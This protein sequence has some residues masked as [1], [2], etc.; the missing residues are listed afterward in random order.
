MWQAE[1]VNVQKYEAVTRL[2]EGVSG[3]DRYGNPV[4]EEL[5]EELP[6]ARFVPGGMIETVSPGRATVMLNPTLYWRHLWPD[7]APSDR[8]VVRGDVYEVE[9]EPGDWQGKRVGGLVVQLRAA[10]EEEEL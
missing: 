9:G 2:R 5:E 4:F 6:K 8:L 10:K 1:G 7:V 3:E